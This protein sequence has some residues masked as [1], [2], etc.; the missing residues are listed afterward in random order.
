MRAAL[1]KF[2]SLPVPHR[3]GPRDQP[4]L[5][6]SLRHGGWYRFGAPGVNYS[7]DQLSAGQERQMTGGIST[8]SFIGF[9]VALALCALLVPAWIARA[10]EKLTVDQILA[11]HAEAI[12]KAEARAAVRNRVAY[13]VASV[14]LR[15]TGDQQ[16]GT[17][18]MA[19][20]GPRHVIAMLFPAT[21]YPHEKV[22]YDGKTVTVG[23][24]SAATKTALGNFI[25]THRQIASEGL[26]GGT[27]STAWPLLDMTGHDA[28]L[29]YAGE[30]KVDKRRAH[31]LKFMPRKG[32][33]IQVH[34]YIDAENFRHIRTEYTRF[35]GAQMT[36]TPEAASRQRETRYTVVEDFADF[37]AEQNLTLPHTYR[38]H[39]TLSGASSSL[40]IDW[41]MRLTQFQF[42]QDVDP[43]TFDVAGS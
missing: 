27:I 41:E 13:G 6:P 16:V 14:T 23:A 30:K 9:A 32:S 7:L 39:L 42:N 11:R 35:I 18:V 8:R 1:Q 22:G 12:G 34:I 36:R 31:C 2:S 5:Q 17:G 15:S 21:E 37:A 24:I 19:S 29:E 25:L 43:K 20:E 38:L 3:S 28:D 33:D 10:E 26:L 4:H 40:M